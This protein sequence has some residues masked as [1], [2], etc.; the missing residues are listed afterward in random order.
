MKQQLIL[1]KHIL[2]ETKTKGIN[3]YLWNFKY[4]GNYILVSFYCVTPTKSHWL[5][6]RIYFACLWVFR[7]VLLLCATWVQLC[8]TSLSFSLDQQLLRTCSSQGEW[9][10]CKTASDTMRGHTR[11]LFLHTARNFPLAKADQQPSP[12]S[13][14]QKAYCF[15]SGRHSEVTW[16]RAHMGPK[17][18]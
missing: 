6:T 14:Q 1:H 16:R 18:R 13:V 5:T 8:C 11:S 15:H 12:N 3:T 7:P 10:E 4:L 17:S 2:K 9:Q